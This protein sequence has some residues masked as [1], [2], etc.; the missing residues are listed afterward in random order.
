MN[1]YRFWIAGQLSTTYIKAK[2]LQ[3]AKQE[4]CQRGIASG[5]QIVDVEVF[6]II[7]QEQHREAPEFP[8][9]YDAQ[10]NEHAEY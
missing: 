4:L 9:Y 8:T 7:E 3:E 1:I 6:R 5:R 2:S 10:G